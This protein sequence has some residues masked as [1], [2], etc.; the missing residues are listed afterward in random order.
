MSHSHNL[1]L[2]YEFHQKSNKPL[3]DIGAFMSIMSTLLSIFFYNFACH[4]ESHINKQNFNNI[5]EPFISNMNTLLFHFS[6][7]FQLV[8]YNDCQWDIHICLQYMSYIIPQIKYLLIT[9]CKQVSPLI[10][11]SINTPKPTRGLDV[12][13]ISPFLVIDDK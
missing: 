13:S 2:S 10:V 11:L 12:L 4:F 5:L 6:F 1:Y 8:T 9:S 3:I 7:S